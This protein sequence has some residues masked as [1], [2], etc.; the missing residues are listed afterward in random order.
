MIKS[1]IVLGI[2]SVSLEVYSKEFSDKELIERGLVELEQKPV[3][4]NSETRKIELFKYRER[5]KKT[6]V[7][8]AFGLSQ[9]QPINYEPD[10]LTLSFQDLYGVGT[11]NMAEFQMFFRRNYSFATAGIELGFGFYQRK[12]QDPDPGY[13]ITLQPMRVG[14]RLAF[15][16]VWP[17]PYFVPY[18]AAGGYFVFFGEEDATRAFKGVTQM[19]PYATLGMAF[20]LDWMDPIGGFNSHIEHGIQNTFLY[21]EGRTF[22]ASSVARDPDFSTDIHL[23][24]GLDLEY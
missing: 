16:T 5:R 3:S 21:V 10:F 12:S 8:Y 7:S 13:T 2:F 4:I 11:S 6:G 15:D 19:A 23:N 14:G 22:I 17:E 1:L 20:Q 18:V 9:F 24:M